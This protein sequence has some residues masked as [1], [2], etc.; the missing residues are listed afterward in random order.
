MKK[1]N[2]KWSSCQ[3]EHFDKLHFNKDVRNL[4]LFIA[5]EN[6]GTFRNLRSCLEQH[7]YFLATSTY[8]TSWPVILYIRYVTYMLIDSTSILGGTQCTRSMLQSLISETSLFISQFCL[9]PVLLD[10]QNVV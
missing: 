1:E 3:L 2:L 4:V 7:C 8:V 9:I 5:A 6:K 10:L